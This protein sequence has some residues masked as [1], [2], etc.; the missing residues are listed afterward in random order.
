MELKR[1]RKPVYILEN[2]IADTADTQRAQFITDHI[3]QVDRA[4]RD[5]LEVRG[6]FYWS[7]LDNFEWAYGFKPRFGLVAIN[8][9]TLERT[10]RPS[11]LE[12]QK[13]IQS[14]GI[15]K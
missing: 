1:Y 13:L 12:Y 7:L 9:A 2:G 15:L 14:S 8:Y 10:V 6:Y 11:A 3:K 5:G 4:Q